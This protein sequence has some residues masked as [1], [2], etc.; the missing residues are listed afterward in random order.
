M[1]SEQA[2]DTGSTWKALEQSVKSHNQHQSDAETGAAESGSLPATR[3]DTT[4]MGSAS[5]TGGLSDLSATTKET[6]AANFTRRRLLR[7]CLVG[8]V[9]LACLAFMCFGIVVFAMDMRRQRQGTS[10]QNNKPTG[11]D[12]HRDA[13]DGTYSREASPQRPA[14]TSIF[15]GLRSSLG[16]SNSDSATDE[17]WAEHEHVAIYDLLHNVV[18][19]TAP[20]DAATQIPFLWSPGAPNFIADEMLRCFPLTQ[21]S[22]TINRVGRPG[23]GSAGQDLQVLPGKPDEKGSM[24]DVD[25]ATLHG[26]KRASD[27]FLFDRHLADYVAS[28]FLPEILSMFPESH[29]GRIFTMII[30]PKARI[31]A[32]YNHLMQN[33]YYTGSLLDFVRSDHLLANDY[34]VRTLTGK[35][36]VAVPLS[37]DDV[38]LA[39]EVL[40][41]KFHAGVL[42]NYKEWIIS[43]IETFQ[44]DGLGGYSCLFPDDV[45]EH[46]PPPPPDATELQIWTF[47]D[48]KNHYDKL[49][50][51]ALSDQWEYYRGGANTPTELGPSGA[52]AQQ[53]EAEA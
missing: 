8:L 31:K 45:Q 5:S 14:D 39:L 29:K 41:T 7:R 1:G 50:L 12:P 3:E 47:I 37:D 11:Q 51:L 24:L 53:Q 46:T 43:V 44:W 30:D 4:V 18:S 10:Q 22:W 9:I 34:T 42:R 21:A 13:F 15:A 48:K 19:P 32:S 2:A 27:Y 23:E 38:S 6:R 49:L 40:R 52:Q 33:G 20:Y 25:M 28:P 26:L 17:F 16:L 36:D 35:W